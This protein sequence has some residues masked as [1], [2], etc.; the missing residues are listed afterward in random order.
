MRFEF[1]LDPEDYKIQQ[2]LKKNIPPVG[3]FD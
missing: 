2:K 1:I 3:I